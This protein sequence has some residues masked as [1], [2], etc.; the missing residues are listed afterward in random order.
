MNIPERLLK[1]L[2][3]FGLICFAWIFFRASSLD[4]AIYVI[5]HMFDGIPHLFTYIRVGLNDVGINTWAN[6]LQL[7][8]ILGVLTLYDAISLKTDVFV[9]LGKQHWLVRWIIYITLGLT[10][11]LLAQ[12]GINTE[13]V[14]FQF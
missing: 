5:V 9:W 12:K 3:I 2:F 13:F 10:T 7:I 11:I 8:G 14:Y 4:D 6:L 1:M